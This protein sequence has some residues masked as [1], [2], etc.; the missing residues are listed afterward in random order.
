MEKAEVLNNFFAL[1]FTG[2]YSSHTA[3]FTESKGR[4]WENEEPLTTAEDEVRDHLRSLK[5]HKSLGHHEVNPRI[6]RE[7]ADEVAKPLSII[8]EKSWQSGEVPGDWKRGN[9]T[10]ILKKGK[11]RRPRELQ[12]SQ[13]HLCAQQDHGADPPGNCPNALRANHA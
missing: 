8:S 3:H 11:K 6:L 2:K 9:I 10:S 4:D 5:V 13:S 1:V 7:M 12:A